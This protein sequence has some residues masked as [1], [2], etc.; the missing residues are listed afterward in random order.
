MKFENKGKVRFEYYCRGD[1]CQHIK[2]ANRKANL[3]SHINNAH[4]GDTQ[5]LGTQH[6]G[7][8][9]EP[10]PER[11]RIAMLNTSSRRTD[12]FNKT[13]TKRTLKINADQLPIKMSKVENE[14]KSKL[15]G[16]NFLQQFDEIALQEYTP[17]QT[18]DVPF[19]YEDDNYI[20]TPIEI[21]KNNRETSDMVYTQV[22]EYIKKVA[23]T[24]KR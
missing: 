12:S 22:Y 24:E 14:N 17:K 21:E 6:M 1:R 4:N 19:E 15:R 2:R 3:M 23:Q 9:K 13:P 16:R 8:S 18:T 7:Y 20:N 5:F 10:L 11:I